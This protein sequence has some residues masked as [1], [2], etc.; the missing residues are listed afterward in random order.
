MKHIKIYEN[1]L[2]DKKWNEQKAITFRINDKIAVG[3][4]DAYLAYATMALIKGYSCPFGTP[5]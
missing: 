5:V 1:Y 3:S 2:D 4:G